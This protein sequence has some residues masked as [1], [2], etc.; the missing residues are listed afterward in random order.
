VE[1]VGRKA[2]YLEAW[3]AFGRS[4]TASVIGGYAIAGDLADRMQVERVCRQ[5]ADEHANATL[6]V[7]AAGL[8]IPKPFLDYDGAPYDSYLELDR[9]TFYLTQTVARGMVE[10]GGGG[11][12]VNIGS[13]RAH[14]AI[15]A[16]P[17]SGYSVGKGGL[18]A[19]TR[20]LAIELAPHQ[21]RVNAVAPAVV[22]TPIYEKFVPNDKLDETLHSFDGIRPL[23]RVGTVRDLATIS[24]LLS[25]ATSWVAGA[26]WNVDGGVMTGRIE[27]ARGQLSESLSTSQTDDH[28]SFSGQ[29]APPSPA[30]RRRAGWRDR[31]RPGASAGSGRWL[32]HLDR[33]ALLQ[34]GIDGEPQSSGSGTSGRCGPWS[35]T[36]T[37]AQ[38][39]EP[40]V[41]FFAR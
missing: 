33:H 26:I 6:L 36:E 16:T 3:L 37:G 25:P 23:G 2:R 32:Q 28:L 8:F 10:Q 1:Q 39:P 29:A 19:L 38:A 5:L 24:F 40:G 7:N 11:A 12:I 31:E 27:R 34:L 30:R 21:I 22:A 20:N 14:Q 13:M 15:G 41:R 35:R 18:H 17:S 4:Q 9:A